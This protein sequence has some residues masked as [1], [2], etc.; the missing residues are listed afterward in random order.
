MLTK[1]SSLIQFGTTVI[2]T[3]ISVIN[4]VITEV[5]IT[6]ALNNCDNVLIHGSLIND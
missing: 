4:F 5:L 6:D 2:S 1:L 3:C